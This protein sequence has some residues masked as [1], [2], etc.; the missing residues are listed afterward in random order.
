M[1]AEIKIKPHHF[2]D[3][4]TSFADEVLELKPHSYEH[5]V[6]IVSKRILDERDVLL[7]LELGAD[8][9]CQPCI[10]N[11]E[12]LCVDT[13][14]ISYRPTAPS[15]KRDY[16]MLLDTRWCKRLNLKQGDKISALNFCKLLSM[17]SGNLQEI[18]KEVPVKYAL[19]RE[20][21]LRKGIKNY[22]DSEVDYLYNV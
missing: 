9:I 7:E 14:D 1:N 15:M 17:N 2:V 6:H 16:N 10:H 22:L 19:K 18:Y 4:I 8:D 13:I 5:S 12:G 3:I 11:I 20:E 21:N